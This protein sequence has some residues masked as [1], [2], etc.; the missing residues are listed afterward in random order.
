MLHECLF[1]WVRFRRHLA[2]HSWTRSVHTV[3]EAVTMWS[4]CGG[5]SPHRLWALQQSPT[6]TQ[7]ST[8]FKKD[9]TIST[10]NME[11]SIQHTWS[12]IQIVELLYNTSFINYNRFLLNIKLNI[13]KI[14]F[15]FNTI[16][17][18][19]FKL[20]LMNTDWKVLSGVQ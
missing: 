19:D 12:K 13:L 3:V 15:M 9:R 7:I 5:A 14:T 1:T 16:Q 6:W 18:K 11:H 4:S 8:K 20:P 10:Y 17:N 2:R